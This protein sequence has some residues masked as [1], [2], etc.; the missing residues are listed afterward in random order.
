[1]LFGSDVCRK[2]RTLMIH[3]VE[4]QECMNLFHVYSFVWVP[5]KN[6][7]QQLWSEFGYLCTALICF[8]LLSFVQTETV[9]CWKWKS[10]QHRPRLIE[11][12]CCSLNLV[13]SFCVLLCHVLFALSFYVPRFPQPKSLEHSNHCMITLQETGWQMHQKP[14]HNCSRFRFCQCASQRRGR[15]RGARPR[16]SETSPG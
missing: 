9:L 1:M 5:W 15:R 14:I 7:I 6:R 3:M 4:Q 8:S 11:M 2:L 16:E 10:Y 13:V 12:L